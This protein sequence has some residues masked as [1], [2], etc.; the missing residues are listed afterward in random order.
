VSTDKQLAQSRVTPEKGIRALAQ[1]RQPARK[2]VTLK[3][4][5]E[6]G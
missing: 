6:I 2:E 5:M 1:T 3:K 4:E